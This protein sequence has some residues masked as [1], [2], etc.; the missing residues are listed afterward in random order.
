MP[1]LVQLNEDWKDR[2]VRVQTV[3]L[4]LATGNGSVNTAAGI[5]EFA[6]DREIFLPILAFE[7]DTGDLANAYKLRAMPLTLAINAKGEI[8]D[9]QT[10]GASRDRFEAM[11]A[12]ALAE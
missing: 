9:R 12:K 2:G 5:G 8:V 10:G 7:G 1:E 4:D 11:I 6:F 3:S